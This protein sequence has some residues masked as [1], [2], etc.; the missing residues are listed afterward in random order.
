MGRRKRMWMG[1]RSR[2]RRRWRVAWNGKRG[3][4]KKG[5]GQCK[6]PTAKVSH[7]L[8]MS[9]YHRCGVKVGVPTS[10][11]WLYSVH[12]RELSIP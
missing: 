11:W 1:S 4:R 7:S 8:G 3:K 10:V 9:P 2:R 12:N 6:R 5:S